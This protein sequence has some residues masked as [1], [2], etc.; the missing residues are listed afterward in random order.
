MLRRGR[1]V[2]A[3]R[4]TGTPEVELGS[5]GSEARRGLAVRQVNDEIRRL[6]PPDTSD[7]VPFFCE[8]AS[9]CFH[10]VWLSTVG[11]DDL[12]MDPEAKL[13]SRGHLDT[14]RLTELIPAS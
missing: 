8:C 1:I 9:G 7:L 2:A 13:L 10:P 11:Y 14:G 3:W 6:S 5:A 12:I 4:C